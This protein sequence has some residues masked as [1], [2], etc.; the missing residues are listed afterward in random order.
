MTIEITKIEDG[1]VHLHDASSFAR[2]ALTSRHGP[3]QSIT[4]HV[5]DG[6]LWIVARRKGSCDGFTARVP[7]LG[8]YT[9][10]VGASGLTLAVTRLQAKIGL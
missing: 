9:D 2:E 5:S 3:E 7:M 6:A 1:Y 4:T 8:N 10:R